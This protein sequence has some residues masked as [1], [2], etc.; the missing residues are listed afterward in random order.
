MVFEDAEVCYA[1]N[2]GGRICSDGRNS[3]ASVISK[4]SLAFNVAGSRYYVM[5]SNIINRG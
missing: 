5:Y 1:F 4:V 2:D 3:Q